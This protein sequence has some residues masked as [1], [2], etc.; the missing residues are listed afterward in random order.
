MHRAWCRLEMLYA[1]NIPLNEHNHAR[2]STFQ[3]GLQVAA[4][5]DRRPHYLYGECETHTYF[6]TFPFLESVAI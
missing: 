4:L 3:A 1:A 2:I 6:L 5:D